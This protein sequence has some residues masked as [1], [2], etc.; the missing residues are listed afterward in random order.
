MTAQ[1]SPSSFYLYEYVERSLGAMD[2]ALVA[3]TRLLLSDISTIIHYLET[4]G[5]QG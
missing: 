2:Q 5:C 3:Q 1:E 4:F